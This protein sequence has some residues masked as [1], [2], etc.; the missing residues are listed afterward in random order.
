LWALLSPPAL[1]GHYLDPYSP[2]RLLTVTTAVSAIAIVIT[3]F[4]IR[5]VEPLNPT[6]S[7]NHSGQVSR[8][9]GDFREALHDI[10]QEP[11]ARIFT[12]FVFVSM[13]A[14]S[15]QDLILE[16][17]AGLVFGRTPGESTQLAGIQHGRCFTWHGG[18]G[19]LDIAL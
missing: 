17:F 10:W 18:H 14:Y 1:L 16:P 19:D 8:R 15:A 13:L 4:A 6:V 5:N 7:Q 12:I 2:E 3:L 11:E 9:S